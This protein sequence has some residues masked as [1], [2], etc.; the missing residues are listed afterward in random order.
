M[1]SAVPYNP[2]TVSFLLAA[3]YVIGGVPF[4][5]A[6]GKLLR[7]VDLRECGSGNIGASNA[8]RVLGWKVGLPVFV[9]DMA[10]GLGPVFAARELF[11]RYPWA[12]VGA[13]LFA[14]LGHNAS[15][16]LRFRGGKGVAT[17]MGVALGLSWKAA[18]AGFCVWAVLLST[19]RFISVSSLAGTPVGAYLIWYWNGRSLPYALF[20]LL[21]T[22]FVVAKHIPNMRRL[23][24]GKEPRI[25]LPRLGDLL[26]AIRRPNPKA[27]T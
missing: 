15:V 5:L 21:A 16:F 13:G 18:A 27:G 9:L 8:W 20:G 19:T 24:A 11:E 4:G 14:I 1:Y 22:I 25:D 17:T 2:E 3:S 12:V 23:A 10:K 26:G 7:G 6:L